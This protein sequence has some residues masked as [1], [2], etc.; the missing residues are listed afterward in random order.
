MADPRM[1]FERLSIGEK[2]VRLC[3]SKT[4]KGIWLAPGERRSVGMIR[5]TRETPIIA[6]VEAASR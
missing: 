6:R 3:C 4:M 5:L 1:G 2:S